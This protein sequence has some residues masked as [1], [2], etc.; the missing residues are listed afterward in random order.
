MR[1]NVHFW[2]RRSYTVNYI[3]MY[4]CAKCE[5]TDIFTKGVLYGSYIGIYT[6]AT[7]GHFWQR[8]SLTR[9]R[10]IYIC[11]YIHK[12]GR[13]DIFDKEGPLPDYGAYIYVGIYTSANGQA[14]LTKGVLYGAYLGI[15]VHV[16]ERTN[17]DFWQKGSLTRLRG[18]YIY[19]YVGIYTTANEQTSLTKGV[20]YATEAHLYT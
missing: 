4:T 17:G 7:N 13:T 2:Q 3:C 19:R 9:L 11:R 16:Q 6:E 18:I 10:G 12:C 1:T 20:P 14:F 15:C 8:G 5:R